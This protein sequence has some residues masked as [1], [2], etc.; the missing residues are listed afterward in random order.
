MSSGV[1]PDAVSP[2]Q[3][4]YAA[5]AL[6]NPGT[7]PLPQSHG[8]DE[9]SQPAA[10]TK[11]DSSPASIQTQLGRTAQYILQLLQSQPQAPATQGRQSLIATAPSAASPTAQASAPTAPALTQQIQQGLRQEVRSSGLF[12]ES[13]LSRDLAGQLADRT[14]L[15]QQPQNQQP[16]QIQTIVRQQL[17]L[18]G[19]GQ[20]EWRGELWPGVELHWQLHRPTDETTDQNHTHVPA[21]ERPWT[22]QLALQLPR[23]GELHVTIS[24]SAAQLHLQARAPEITLSLLRPFLPLLH[25]R[26]AALA[27]QLHIELQPLSQDNP[28]HDPDA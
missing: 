12:Y 22:T 15:Q 21:N 26:L 6:K 4:G 2:T 9:Q 19:S 14:L 3:R 10:P 11:P 18:L 7:R 1:R 13:L 28:P 5:S 25:E 24:W 16:E 23:L 20:W 17:E 27:K 8:A